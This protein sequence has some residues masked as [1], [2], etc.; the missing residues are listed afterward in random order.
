MRSESG[1][2]P[3]DLDQT[4]VVTVEDVTILR[5][6]RS[7]SRCSTEEWL[8]VLARLKGPSHEALRARKGPR[9][10]EPFRL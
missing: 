2:E 5:R 7:S 10:T 4:L 8:R 9:G 1:S 3:L 6:L